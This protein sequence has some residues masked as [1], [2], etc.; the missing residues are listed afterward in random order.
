MLFLPLERIYQPN[1][2]RQTVN[3]RHRSEELAN[4]I[5]RALGDDQAFG[6]APFNAD[7]TWYHAA[8]VPAPDPSAGLGRRQTDRLNGA[9]AQ[10]DAAKALT[11]DALRDLRNALAHGAIHYLDADGHPTEGSFV[12]QL[13]F[14]NRHQ[15]SQTCRIWKVKEEDFHQFL[16]Q[17]AQWLQLHGLDKEIA[18]AA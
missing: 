9:E 5:D 1:L 7:V 3:D 16:Q 4:H 11:R 18:D 13:A 6:A 10:C 17:W 2:R 14:V 8:G 15:N 12:Q